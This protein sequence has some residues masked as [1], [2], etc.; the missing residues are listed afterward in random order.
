MSHPFFKN[1]FLAFFICFSFWLNAQDIHF[2]QYYFSP[3]SLNPASTGNYNGDYRGM[4]NY[5]T[6][7]REIDKA[8]NTISAGGDMNFYPLN[9][10]VSGGLYFVNDKSGGNLTV[11]KIFASGAVHK[12]LMGFDLSLGIQPGVVMKQIDFNDHTF[13]NQFSWNSGYFDKNLPNAETNVQPKTTYFDFNTGFIASKRFNK[14][15]PEL[16]FAFFHLT[17]PKESFL[18]QS[19]KLPV[20]QMYNLSVKYYLND[21]ITIKPHTLMAYTN[22]ASEW[23]SG[24][25]VDY[26]IGKTP[27]FTNSV[28]AGVLFRDGLKT[29]SDAY[30]FTC[31]AHY[32]NYTLGFSYDVNISQL[33]T[34]TNSKGAFEIALIYTAKNTRLIKKE[35]PCDR[36]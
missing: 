7:W 36:L 26:K 18:D 20:R 16:G 22:K 31:G 23:V 14:I 6:Q 24:L 32:L 4:L 10:K 28:F 21:K 19:N 34:A 1:I 15:E 11:N 25:N 27:F 2:T 35:L 33:K 29:Q 8:Y 3:L 9:Q 13:P 5:R 17:K 12:K 30:S